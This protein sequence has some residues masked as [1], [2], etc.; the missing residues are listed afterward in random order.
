L[1]GHELLEGQSCGFLLG[2][3]FGG[4][5]GFG[6]GAS[7]AGDIVDTDF[8]AEAFGV[9]GAGLVGEDVLGLASANGLEMLL[10]SGFVVADGSAERAAG[11]EGVVE[12]G[13]CGFDDLFFDEATGG[14]ESTVEVEG[15]DDGLECVGEDGGLAAATAL[16]FSAAEED[17]VAETDAEGDVPQVAA[18]DEGGSEAGEF[19]LTGGG[20][21]LE[22]GFGGEEAKDGVA[23]ELQLLVIGGGAGERVVFP[24]GICLVGERTMGESP[25]EELGPFEAMM[26]E[27]RLSWAGGGSSGLAWALSQF[28]SLRLTLSE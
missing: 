23:D 6:D 18:A 15:G 13:Q 4:A 27:G 22:E 8:Y 14:G 2:F 17:V 28:R 16:L 11:V 5:F 19:T 20:E 12:F 26:K 25:D 9:V 3:L 21:A 24:G 1:L 7:G 10:E